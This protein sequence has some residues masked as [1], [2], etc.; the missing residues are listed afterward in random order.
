MI[1]F[2]KKEAAARL[3]FVTL[4]RNRDGVL[5]RL[6]TLETDLEKSLKDVPERTTEV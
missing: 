1:G 5:A 6:R 2:E 4:R 3:E